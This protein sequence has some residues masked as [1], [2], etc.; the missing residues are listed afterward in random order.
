MGVAEAWKALGEDPE[1][2]I[3]EMRA[4]PDVQS[5]IVAAEAA[6]ARAERV[7]KALMSAHHPD[8]NQGDEKA[9]KRFRRV[10]TA[11]DSIRFHTA[12]FKDMASRTKGDPKG[13]GPFIVFG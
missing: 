2:L 7:A 12:E 6:L 10:K 3:E 1:E 4:C 9:G 8:K 13:G 5:R 11:I